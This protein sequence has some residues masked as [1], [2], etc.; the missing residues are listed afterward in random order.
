MTSVR[1]C[2]FEI[3]CMAF[4]SVG[5]KSLYIPLGMPLISRLQMLRFIFPQCFNFNPLFAERKNGSWADQDHVPDSGLSCPET[6]KSQ[7]AL[8]RGRIDHFGNIFLLS[9]RTVT[10]DH[11]L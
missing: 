6:A 3:Q 9:P 2:P 10:Y 4:F 8:T 5:Y 1:K 11:N 7:K